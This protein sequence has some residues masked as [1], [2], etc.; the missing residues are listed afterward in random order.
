MKCIISIAMALF[1]SLNA[2]A[3]TAEMTEF[4]KCVVNEYLSQ[5]A[6]ILSSGTIILHTSADSC[7]YYLS[8]FEDEMGYYDVAEMNEAVLNGRQIK[9]SGIELSFLFTGTLKPGDLRQKN[10]Y[11]YINYD[12]VVWYIAFHKD[13]TFCK[14]FTQKGSVS[15]PIDDIASLAEKYLCGVSVNNYDAEYVYNNVMVDTPAEFP[16]SDDIYEILSSNIKSCKKI[17]N[18]SVPVIINLIID[19]YGIAKIDGFVRKYDEEEINI[20]ALRAAETICSYHFTPAK[21]R[22]EKVSVHYALLFPKQIFE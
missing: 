19:K 7:H 8:V 2:I 13:G 12:P 9:V 4:T 16:Y 5:N 15:A 22:G 18:P 17:L 6:G 10:E 21:H 14:M 1:C 20:E 3:Q 11:E